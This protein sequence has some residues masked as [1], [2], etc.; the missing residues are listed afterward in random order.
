MKNLLE[1]YEDIESKDIRVVPVT[2]SNK[3]AGIIH[4][5]SSTLICAD[6]Q[7]FASKKEEKL[8]IAEELAHYDVG[9][10]YKYNCEDYNQINKAEYKAKKKLYNSLIPWPELLSKVKEYKGN[11]EELSDYFGIPEYDVC[12]AFFCYTNIE[13]YAERSKQ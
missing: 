3:K 4:Y 8:C 5:G 9:A 1:V 2:F 7:K 12:L 13:N 10:Y 6:Y 11:I